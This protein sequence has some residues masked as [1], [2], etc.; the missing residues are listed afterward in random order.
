MDYK[1]YQLNI[2]NNA[3]HITRHYFAMFFCKIFLF[4]IWIILQ[5]R[6]IYL[7]NLCWWFKV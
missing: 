2:K 7:G 3:W 4:I 6:A 5:R 1:N